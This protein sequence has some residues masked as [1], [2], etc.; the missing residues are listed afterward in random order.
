[1]RRYLVVRRRGLLDG[2]RRNFGFQLDCLSRIR[3]PD[4][5]VRNELGPSGRCLISRALMQGSGWSGRRVTKVEA[6][7]KRSHKEL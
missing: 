3:Y 4:N 2:V 6:Q 5:H 7:S 1:M